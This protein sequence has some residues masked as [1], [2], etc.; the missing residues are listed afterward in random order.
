MSPQDH[1]LRTTAAIIA[2][3]IG[4]MLAGPALAA[5]DM[6]DNITNG[7]RTGLAGAE[8][9]M[10]R[11]A[12][13]IFWG[14]A[15]IEC[16]Y[17]MIMVT[18][19]KGSPADFMVEI[20]KRI[21]FVGVMS[22]LLNNS[23]EWGQAMVNTMRGLGDQ[24][25]QGA[26]GSGGLRPTDVFTAG[27]NIATLI[28]NTDTGIGIGAIGPKLALAIAGLI[29]AIVFGLL[30]ALMIIAI[31]KSYFITS[32]GVVMMGLAGS[33]WTKDM[34]IGAF[35]APLEVG[36]ELLVLQIIIGLGE[37]QIRSY[38]AVLAASNNDIGTVLEIVVAGVVFLAVGASIPGYVA[39]KLSG[40]G[41]GGG[42][43]N[44]VA[45]AAAQV[46][47]AAMG[48]AAGV[49]GAGMAVNQAA[50]MAAEQHSE[51]GGPGGV[52]GLM[53]VAGGA[54]ATLGKAAVADVGSRLSGGN[55]HGTVGG[56]MAKDI[57]KQRAALQRGSDEDKPLEPS[58]AAGKS[59]A[60]NAANSDKSSGTIS[61]AG[62]RAGG[63]AN[64]ASGADAVD[65]GAAKS[66]AP[67]QGAPGTAAPAGSWRAEREASGARSAD[68][69][70]DDGAA[71][72]AERQSAQQFQDRASRDQTEE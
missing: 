65:G 22:A 44:P 34:A 49:A 62:K 24:A 1:Q 7:Y 61:G 10:R 66:G 5:G 35:K 38:P 68:A 23:S 72:A 43:S 42:G 29:V 26:G 56:R 9:P 33:R 46:G 28:W 57:G 25:A 58:A 40:G 14:L 60:D 21:L 16:T 67:E 30:C 39:S 64:N 15:V 36:V 12:N 63:S 48:V 20:M 19:A 13:G 11:F 32:I 4:L 51:K 52:S 50:K 2:L 45:T 6:I 37:A 47:G 71:R 8:A 31:V 3:T 18:L 41:G 54:A 59:K 55:R 69:G 17:A 70:N 27:K 53:S